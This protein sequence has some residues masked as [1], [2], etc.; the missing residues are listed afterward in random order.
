MSKE[1][2]VQTGAKQPAPTS[3]DPLGLADRW[4]DMERLFSLRPGFFHPFL[5]TFRNMATGEWVPSIDVYKE[6]GNL[7]VKA[8][9]P[10][11]KKTDIHVSVEHGDLIIQGERKEEKEL[12][13]EDL[14]R[15]E[16]RTGS[17]F[18]RMSLGFEVEPDKVDA[19]FRDG[20]LEIRV[21]KP[22][23]KAPTAKK[24]AIK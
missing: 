8:D 19:S 5:S 16:R 7:V 23:E 1:T 24:V 12:K 2:A 14:F 13:Q 15:V 20:V 18:R 9:L 11:I 10:G 17:F 3:W 21:P 6:N 4:A 22:V